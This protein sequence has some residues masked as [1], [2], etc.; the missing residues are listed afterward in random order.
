MSKEN[1]ESILNL[2]VNE[3]QDLLRMLALAGWKIGAARRINCSEKNR[4]AK[5]LKALMDKDPVLTTSFKIPQMYSNKRYSSYADIIKAAIYYPTE[6]QEKKIS[7]QSN[8]RGGLD[9]PKK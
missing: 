7:G 8:L 3:Q 5:R 6:D 1:H 4:C 2:P 9:P